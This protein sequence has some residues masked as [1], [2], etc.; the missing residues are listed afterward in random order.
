MTALETAM[1]DADTLHSL[2]PFLKNWVWGT[3]GTR[4]L[5]CRDGEIKFDDG[6][7]GCCRAPSEDSSPTFNGVPHPTGP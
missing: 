3:R 1:V 4:Y 7:K 5:D 6:K 2:R